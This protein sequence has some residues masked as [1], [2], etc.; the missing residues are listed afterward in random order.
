MIKYQKS[1][2]KFQAGGNPFNLYDAAQKVQDYIDKNLKETTGIDLKEKPLTKK[3]VQADRARRN[4]QQNHKQNQTTKSAVPIA[5]TLPAVGA[6]VSRS[7]PV[8]T[9]L[10]PSVLSAPAM[11]A[12]NLL[13]PTSTGKGSTIQEQRDAIEYGKRQVAEDIA[14]GNVPILNL[15]RRNNSDLTGSRGGTMNN[16]INYRAQNIPPVNP[17]NLPGP[18][19]NRFQRTMD[20]LKDR[21]KKGE[22]TQSTQQGSDKDS[23]IVGTIW[24]YGKYPFLIGSGGYL[25]SRDW[26][27]GELKLPKSVGE[28]FQEKLDLL[29]KNGTINTS[30][31]S[32]LQG[33]TATTRTNRSASEVKNAPRESSIVQEEDQYFGY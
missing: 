10:M 12:I 1:I 19:R 11:A 25:F 2:A 16:H 32:E 22:S 23:G 14:A 30:I 24:K 4:Y 26:S 17:N 6:T 29:T 33:D 9:G 27:T 20:Y 15:E 18:R 8:V 13:Y 28:S 3:D 5:L 7:L 21:F 31:N